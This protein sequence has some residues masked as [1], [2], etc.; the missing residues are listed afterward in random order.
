MTGDL[1]VDYRT[2]ITSAQ[3]GFG[4][5]VLGKLKE[6]QT[7]TFIACGYCSQE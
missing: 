1:I 5:Q 6:G 4:G 3:Y 7:Y 2:Q